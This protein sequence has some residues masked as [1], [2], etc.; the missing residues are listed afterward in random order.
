MSSIGRGGRF[1]PYPVGKGLSKK[2][3]KIIKKREEK[4][5]VL[6]AIREDKIEDPYGYKKPDHYAAEEHG[7]KI[8]F[9]KEE[10]CAGHNFRV[11]LFSQTTKIDVFLGASST[12]CRC[13]RLMFLYFVFA[14]FAVPCCFARHLSKYGIKRNCLQ[15][16]QNSYK[17]LIPRCFPRV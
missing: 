3:R 4:I 12:K 5:K 17:Q 7:Y 16:L 9:Q 1:F 6:K 13:S 11:S 14:V 15:G 2:D 8:E 10:L